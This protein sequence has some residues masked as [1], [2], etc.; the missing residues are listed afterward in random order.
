MLGHLEQQLATSALQ[1]GVVQHQTRNPFNHFV[2]RLCGL[3]LLLIF[4]QQDAGIYV[5][6]AAQAP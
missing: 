6:T 2:Q 3:E 5:V 4:V 1:P